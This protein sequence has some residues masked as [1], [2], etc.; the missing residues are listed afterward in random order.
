MRVERRPGVHRGGPPFPANPLRQEQDAV[1][2]RRAEKRTVLED[3][4]A[5]RIDSVGVFFDDPQEGIFNA[6]EH[7]VR[8]AQPGPGDVVY[9]SYF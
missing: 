1:L 4:P 7:R 6:A 9:V 2:V 5:E 8:S 3:I